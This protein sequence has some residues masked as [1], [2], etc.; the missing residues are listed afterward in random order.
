MRVLILPDATMV[1]RERSL[2][3][4]LEVGLADEGIR[5][6]QGIPR[7]LEGHEASSTLA[8][9]VFAQAMMFEDRGLPFTGGVRARLLARDLMNALQE[10]PGAEGIDAVLA[11]GDESWTFARDVAQSVG[12]SLVLEIHAPRQIT[13]AASLWRRGTRDTRAAHPWFVV[14]G[15]ALAA[16][17]RRELPAD[18]TITAPWG[19]HAGEGVRSGLS[20]EPTVAILASGLHAAPVR[21]ALE[22]LAGVMREFPAMHVLVDAHIVRTLPVWRWAGAMPGLRERLSI[23]A[24]LDGRHDVLTSADVL[25][26]PEPLGEHRSV[27]LQAMADGML[28]A[29]APDPCLDWLVPETSAALGEAPSRG[30]SERPHS[31]ASTG[32]S[33]RSWSGVSAEA[34]RGALIGPRGL[35]TDVERAESLRRCAAEYVRLHF[36]ASGHVR[37]IL[38]AC[39]SAVAERDAAPARRL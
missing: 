25:L 2:L 32:T 14:A 24:E 15:E 4:R 11:T 35:L 22:A 34:I 1:L 12:A 9:S 30:G 33:S 6:L 31:D 10:E 29:A 27:V 7:S 39:E 16:M 38:G 5:V 13:R 17:V 18:R 19:V 37:A 20:P 8:R 21:A 3:A 28:V 23:I 26:V 36:P